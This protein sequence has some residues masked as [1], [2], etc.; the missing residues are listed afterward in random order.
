MIQPRSQSCNLILGSEG[1]G[2]TTLEFQ[3]AIAT[4]DANPAKRVLFGVTDNSDKKIQMLPEITREELSSFNGVKKIIIEDEE[5][6]HDFT[7]LF[8]SDEF[9]FDGLFIGDDLKEILTARPKEVI[10]MMTKRRHANLDIL[11]CFHS[12]HCDTPKGFF[13]H[14]NK[15]YLFRTSD[16][17][18]DF[19]KK[20]PMHKRESFMKAY[21]R[22]QRKSEKQ[23]NYFEEIIINPLKRY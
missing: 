1:T 3:I 2:K 5:I 10:T 23:Q 11:F 18:E 16:A 12:L 13:G 21:D 20:L 19:V 8:A 6:F 7:K 22:V 17:H 4:L 9:Q 14:I 15:I